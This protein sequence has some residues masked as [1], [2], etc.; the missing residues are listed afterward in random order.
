MNDIPSS[1]IP[2]KF[3]L[4]NIMGN[5]FTGKVGDQKGCASCYTMSFI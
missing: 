3:D 1:E 5:D 4:S 2:E